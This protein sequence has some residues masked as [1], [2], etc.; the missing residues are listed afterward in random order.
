MFWEV[1]HYV[2]KGAEDSNSGNRLNSGLK[3]F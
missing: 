3:D 2:K 1:V